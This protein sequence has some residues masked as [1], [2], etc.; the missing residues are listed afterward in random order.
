MQRADALHQADTDFCWVCAAVGILFGIDELHLIL[1]Q[2][3]KIGVPAAQ[4]EQVM[5]EIAYEFSYFNAVDSPSQGPA[6]AM[7]LGVM[8]F[9]I[10]LGASAFMICSG[11]I[12]QLSLPATLCCMQVVDRLQ[13]SCPCMA[14]HCRLC[15]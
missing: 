9:P 8:L 2:L 11:Q 1:E 13:D 12:S 15:C 7:Q 14:S 6:P 3:L 4:A 10:Q 5:K